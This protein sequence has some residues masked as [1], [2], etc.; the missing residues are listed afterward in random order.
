[1]TAQAQLRKIAADTPVSELVFVALD[2]ETTGLDLQTDRPVD[3]G[4]VR[5]RIGQIEKTFESLVD[6]ARTIPT[7]TINIHHITQEMVAGA[8]AAG[9]ALDALLPVLD[10]A[11]LL[12]HNAPFD[13]AIL[14]L[15]ARRHGRPIPPLL[16]LDTCLLAAALIHDRPSLRLGELMSWL[17]LPEKNSHRALP[18]ARCAMRLFEHCIARMSN[19]NNVT[20]GQV[21]GRH[22]P[23]FWLPDF[24]AHEP[25]WMWNFAVAVNAVEERLPLTVQYRSDENGPQECRIDPERFDDS[26]GRWC[27]QGRAG[28]VAGVPMDA[29]LSMKKIMPGQG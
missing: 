1:M 5:F 17:G 15:T 26:S 23:A 19:G 7:E 16:V 25:G 28:T 14:A 4:A 8:P 10:G 3:I 24:G 11:I 12:A 29:L 6:P 20:W 9:D 2:T 18:D 22:G 27:L 21:I 13:M